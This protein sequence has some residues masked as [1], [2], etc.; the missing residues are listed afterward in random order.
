[1]GFFT[2]LKTLGEATPD[3]VLEMR[4]EEERFRKNLQDLEKR[5]EELDAISEQL[6]EVASQSEDKQVCL[7]ATNTDLAA[8]LEKVASIPPSA[9]ETRVRKEDDVA[10]RSGELSAVT[11]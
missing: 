4:R 1:M 2:F 10:D 11:A 8:M 6:D 7:T 5:G 3:K 9:S